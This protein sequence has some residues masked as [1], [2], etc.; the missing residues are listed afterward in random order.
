MQL[1]RIIRTATPTGDDFSMEIYKLFND[2]QRECLD[3]T[4]NELLE[5]YTICRRRG[6]AGD[7]LIAGIGVYIGAKAQYKSILVDRVLA[8]L[9]KGNTTRSAGRE[10]SEQ[11]NKVVQLRGEGRVS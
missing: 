1:K 8:L 11:D 4:Y 9:D 10:K 2:S 5:A 7:A 6:L 3:D